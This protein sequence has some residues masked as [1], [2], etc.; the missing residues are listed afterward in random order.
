MSHACKRGHQVY[1][2]K[3]TIFQKSTTPRRYWFQAIFM[4]SQT[5]SGVSAATLSR[6]IGVNYKTGWR[7]FKQIRTLMKP[8]ESK[9]KGV[10][11]VDETWIGGKNYY[12]GKKWW[13]SY[14][15]RS[16]VIV[17]GMIE[18]KG[19]VRTFIIPDT[20][21]MTLR[22]HIK[23]NIEPGTNVI[24]DGHNGYWGLEKIGYP[25]GAVNHIVQYVSSENPSVH[26]QNIEGF[27]GQMKRGI[28][29]VYRHVS[30]E[31]LLSYC[32]EYGFRH[33]PR[34]K[35]IFLALLRGVLE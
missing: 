27:W 10:V 2:L 19:R 22:N 15:D 8:E 4:M 18:R 32:N 13:S 6:T 5:R 33:N 31:Y 7:M 23:D 9:L 21:R 24:T 28:T 34:T 16:K 11:E 29:G 1:P 26:T 20:D 30:P 25:H 17:L 35:N 3:G 12:K 14:A